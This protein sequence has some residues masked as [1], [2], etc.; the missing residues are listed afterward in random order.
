MAKQSPFFVAFAVTVGLIAGCTAAPPI[1]TSAVIAWI[2][3]GEFCEP[4]TVLPLPDDTLLVSNVCDF[5]TAGNGYLT[6]LDGDGDSI[7]W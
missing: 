4:E 2:T 5:G 6:L 3:H 7:N 1:P